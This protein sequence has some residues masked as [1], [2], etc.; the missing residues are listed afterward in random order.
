MKHIINKIVAGAFMFLTT[1]GIIS[2]TDI[3]EWETD[4]QSRSTVQSR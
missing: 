2:C 1:A 3:N 4:S